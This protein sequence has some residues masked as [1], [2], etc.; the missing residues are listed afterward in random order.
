M[1]IKKK[2]IICNLFSDFI[3]EKIGLDTN[4]KIQVTDCSNFYTINSNSLTILN[5]NET[6]DEFN[7]KFKTFLGEEKILRTIDL[8]NYGTKLTPTQKLKYKFYNTENC[9]YPKDEINDTIKSYTTTSTFPHGHSFTMGR[10]LLYKLKNIAYN[11]FNLG[12]IKWLDIDMNCNE[13]EDD[14]ISISHNLSP[15]KYDF[16]KSAILDVFDIQSISDMG[17]NKYDIFNESLKITRESP[18]IKI[19]YKDFMVV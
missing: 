4:T 11:V 8:I 16:I 12:Y 5:I 19:L 6:V 15:L 7:L 1:N 3:L 9:L 2:T 14:I 18:K 17:I 10:S 13:V